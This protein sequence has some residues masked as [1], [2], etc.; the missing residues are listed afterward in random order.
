MRM[1]F[2]LLSWMNVSFDMHVFLLLFNIE[3]AEPGC[4]SSQVCQA[5][6]CA[7]FGSWKRLTVPF[8]AH[9][10]KNWQWTVVNSVTISQSRDNFSWQSLAFVQLVEKC[11]STFSHHHLELSMRNLEKG[12]VWVWAFQV[13]GQ[14]ISSES[15]VWCFSA[16]LSSLD[17][18][19]SLLSGTFSW[20]SSS[21]L[22]LFSEIF[23]MASLLQFP[24]FFPLPPDITRSWELVCCWVLLKT[25]PSSN[26]MLDQDQFS[27][28]KLAFFNCLKVFLKGKRWPFEFHFHPH[29]AASL[30][31]QN[32]HAFLHC[33]SH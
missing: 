26:N 31:Q 25:K 12:F 28:D 18:M 4:A 29:L 9:P 27:L 23:L 2:H 8:D 7:S 19:N 33:Q 6:L 11:S 3:A 17:P 24:C 13:K 20:S 5:P 21:L 15:P 10:D 14:C 16:P 32:S 30:L 1:S 22:V